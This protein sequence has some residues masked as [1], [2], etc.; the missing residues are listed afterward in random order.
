MT[1]KCVYCGSTTEPMHKDHLIPQSRG[2]SDEVENCV[3]ACA[4]C[5]INK[6]DKTP[7]EWQPEG[8]P[9]WVYEKE[10]VLSTKYR[11]TPRN[12]RGRQIPPA[13]RAQA[14]VSKRSREY[15]PGMS[16]LVAEY[17]I[18]L[19][20]N[21]RPGRRAGF[22]G[23]FCRRP[24]EYAIGGVLL[25]GG[26]A[27]C[28]EC[29]KYYSPEFRIELGTDALRARHILAQLREGTIPIAK[30]TK[31]ALVARTGGVTLDEYIDL[32]LQVLAGDT[33]LRNSLKAAIPQL[34]LEVWESHTEGH[35]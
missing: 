11:M 1:R 10:R 8:L 27:H 15:L 14:G 29:I 21:S 31:L 5:N 2:G 25:G 28:H 34:H 24:A 16:L 22:S 30:E 23:D 19:E 13:G 26:T 6:T 12:K 33:V 17:P 7:S 3:L 35:A 18:C 32:A 9:T 20:S 4:A